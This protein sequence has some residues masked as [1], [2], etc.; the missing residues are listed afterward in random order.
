MNT[1]FEALKWASSYLKEA[2][3]DE[4]AAEILLLHELNTDRSR[5]LA[6]LHDSI[7]DLELDRFRSKVYKHAEGTPVQYI[8][9]KEYFYGR[10]FLVNEEVLI[11]RPETEEVVLF[12]LSK[13]KEVFPG[14]KGLQAVDV[15]TGSGAIAI[16]MALENSELSVTA[17]DISEASLK[18]A[19]ENAARLGAEVKFVCGD[20][21]RSLIQA[22]KKADIIVSN[23]PY[24]S[25]EEL[26][27]LS[28]TVR[29][30][31]PVRALTDGSDGLSFYKR[32]MEEL[33]YVLAD[34]GIVVFEI[35]H[36]QGTAVR[37]LLLNAFPQAEVRV[38]Q[39]ING[40]DRIVYAVIER[41]KEHA[42]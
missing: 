23:P 29:L 18:V 20:L 21:L 28:E 32:F 39:D 42:S 34:R 8:T 6:S 4:N 38:K 31:E 10:E 12:A 11:P 9:G 36:T 22:N 13:M 27:S 16:T 19:S 24:I 35:G 41:R 2:G 17:T 5:L 1:V 33:P 40:K 25:L 7:S 14:K 37:S 30:H 15:G 26:E 3:R